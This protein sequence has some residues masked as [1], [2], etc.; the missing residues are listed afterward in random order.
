MKIDGNGHIE[1]KR[2]LNRVQDMDKNQKLEKREN[3]QNTESDKD[4]VTLSG[5]A[6]DINELKG[7]IE[8]LPDIRQ[9][10]VDAVK[11]AVDTGNYNFDSLKIAQRM[12]LE[13]M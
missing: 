1:D 9:D 11:R 8:G 13:E 4:K 5:K 6:K 12:L 3:A 10:K 2:T 7:L